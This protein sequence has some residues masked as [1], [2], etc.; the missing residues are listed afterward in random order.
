M[1]GRYF[2]VLAQLPGPRPLVR[3]R[4][5][6]PRGGPG[7]WL[8]LWMGSVLPADSS[9]TAARSIEICA[10]PFPIDVL[11]LEFDCSVHHTFVELDAV[12]L[13]GTLDRPS[14][15]FQAPVDFVYR[16]FP[17][18]WGSDSFTF[19]L[20]DCPSDYLRI[21]P[22]ITYN[23]NLTFKNHPPAAL[24]FPSVV[25]SQGSAV[26]ILLNGTDA[27]L[28]TAPQALRWVLLR[29]PLSG[30]LRARCCSASEPVLQVNST[31]ALGSPL[32]YEAVQDSGPP[33]CGS[34][35]SDHFTVVLC[36]ELDSCDSSRAVAVVS[37][38]CSSC[39]RPYVLSHQ[40]DGVWDGKAENA[41]NPVFGFTPLKRRFIVFWTPP[42]PLFGLWGL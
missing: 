32:W 24:P 30:L 7:A 27:D 12:Q 15:R 19:A 23:L 38:L 39:P 5:P 37:M 29:L 8:T 25:A 6:D 14:G 20:S 35:F 21:T 40:V 10:T 2:V 33:R 22:Q 11:R 42:T 13:V 16:P 1:H 41:V 34:Q 17:L 9:G 28:T 26:E 36:D 4:T 31:L 18:T 3:V